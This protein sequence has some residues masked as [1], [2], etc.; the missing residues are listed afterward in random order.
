MPDIIEEN[1]GD[2]NEIMRRAHRARAAAVL[3]QIAAENNNNNNNNNN[4]QHRNNPRPVAVPAAPAGNNNNNNNNNNAVPAAAAAAAAPN[5]NNNNNN[6]D[7]E[8]NAAA[9]AINEVAVLAGHMARLVGGGVNVRPMFHRLGVQRLYD[10]RYI[11][12]KDLDGIPRVSVIQKRKLWAL[13]K[14]VATDHSV[15]ASTTLTH[16]ARTLNLHKKRDKD[17]S[18]TNNTSGAAGSPANANNERMAIMAGFNPLGTAA[19]PM[20]HVAELDE[21]DGAYSNWVLWN[22]KTR[23]G[24]AQT[25][26]GPLLLSFRVSPA[27]SKEKD[28]NGTTENLALAH[29]K[30]YPRH[31]HL[32]FNMLAQAIVG[33][34]AKHLIRKAEHASREES[35]SETAAAANEAAASSS[36]KKKKAAAAA[37]IPPIALASGR[38]LWQLLQEEYTQGPMAFWIISD[39]RQ[40]LQKLHLVS[41][42]DKSNPPDNNVISA[43]ENN[44]YVSFSAQDFVQRFRAAKEVLE[45]YHQ[46]LPDSF[47]AYTFVEHIQDDRLKKVQQQLIQ[48]LTTKQL[49][50]DQCIKEVLMADHMSRARS[51]GTSGRNQNLNLNMLMGHAYDIRSNLKRPFQGEKGHEKDA[52]QDDDNNTK[53]LKLGDEGNAVASKDA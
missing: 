7:N 25:S 40:I 50:L 9:A 17:N 10:V 3:A 2:G 4:N 12:E 53:R 35:S 44:E 30:R 38:K 21:F 20:A 45:D 28:G 48:D 23:Y 19:I 37:T 42:C 5:D 18:A 47:L 22:H 26:L 46:E 24:L 6:N 51:S 15:T 11:R 49:N 14:Y 36:S 32:L 31:D 41:P 13:A 29:A 33:G 39:A 34:S 1:E 8:A 16:V 43:T 52:Q 27:A